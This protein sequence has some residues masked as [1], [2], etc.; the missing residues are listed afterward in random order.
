[1]CTTCAQSG[2][3]THRD[4]LW[5]TGATAGTRW[6]RGR[7][8]PSPTLARRPP[9][10]IPRRGCSGARRSAAQLELGAAAGRH[11]R[12]RH[13]RRAAPARSPT[14][15]TAVPR[16]RSRRLAA[17][18]W[19]TPGLL[20]PARDRRATRRRA[21]L[22]LA[23]PAAG[24][25]ADRAVGSRR[26]RAAGAARARRALHR[27][28]PGRRAGRPARSRPCS[29]P[30]ASAA[31]T[32]S[33]R[34]RPGCTTPSR[35]ACC[36]ADEGCPS[37]PRPPRRSHRQA[38]ETDCLPLPFGEPP[39]L[40][41]LAVDEPI[42]PRA[43]RRAARPRRARTCWCRLGGGTASVGPLVL[44]GPHQLPALRRPAPPRSRPGL[45][46]ARRA[47]DRPARPAA[48]ARSPWPTVIA[49]VGGDAGARLPRRRP[50]GHDRG[51]LEMQAPD[52]RLRRR[53]WPMHPDCDCLA[54]PQT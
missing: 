31:S 24:R 17:S 2:S 44:P 7:V 40:V 48:R 20:W 30:P 11:R 41:V 16:G 3:R 50:A 13:R 46:R 26:R 8:T 51:S 27:R 49:G 34:R 54:R 4:A 5:I 38:P 42:D 22:R 14:A 33:T 36:P 32:S 10:C 18:T 1:M 47:A 15:P 39:D 12:R 21:D 52:W 6:H 23:P 45:E 28:R 35:A 53:S 29:P 25:R 37:P 9:S 43:A 19:S